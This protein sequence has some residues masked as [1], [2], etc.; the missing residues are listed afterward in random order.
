MGSPTQECITHFKILDPRDFSDSPVVNKLLYGVGHGGF[1]LGQGTKIPHATE[2]L[3]PLI[4]T[5][6]PM[7]HSERSHMMH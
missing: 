2:Q 1:I 4:A 3:S 6:E 7:G 5:R